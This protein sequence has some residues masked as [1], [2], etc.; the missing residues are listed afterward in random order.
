[1]RFKEYISEGYTKKSA[2]SNSD[3]I[4]KELYDIV[5][6]SESARN[7]LGI[8]NSDVKPNMFSIVISTGGAGASYYAPKQ[9]IQTGKKRGRRNI[10]QYEYIT[11]RWYDSFFRSNQ[12]R[13]FAT[14]KEFNTFMDQMRRFKTEK[15]DSR[16]NPIRED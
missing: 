3:K 9:K 13:M 5:S 16:G 7:F 14:A 1:M 8:L 11:I 12:D 10:R 4:A 15:L 6:T 2:V